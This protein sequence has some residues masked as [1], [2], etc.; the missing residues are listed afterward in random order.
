MS[1]QGVGKG[2][3]SLAPRPSANLVCDRG[4]QHS[5]STKSAEEDKDPLGLSIEHFNQFH[6]FSITYS[7]GKEMGFSVTK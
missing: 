7:K 3:A 1:L 4:D 5:L 6:R 2:E